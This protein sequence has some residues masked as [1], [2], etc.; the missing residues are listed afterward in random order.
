MVASIRIQVIGDTRFVL[1]R[2]LMCSVVDG[3]FN[4]ISDHT[5]VPPDTHTFVLTQLYIMSSQ[6]VKTQT[7]NE[8]NENTNIRRTMYQNH[9]AS[10]FVSIKL[11]CA[12]LERTRS[13]MAYPL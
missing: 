1:Y 2:I 8:D 6:R 4:G 11:H 12:S 5:S 7:W 13:N 10:A 3:G 9:L